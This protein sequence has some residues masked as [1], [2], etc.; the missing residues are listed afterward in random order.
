MSEKYTYS[1]QN[2]FP[3]S[4][5]NPGRLTEEIQDSSISGALD[6]VNTDADDDDCDIWF[7]ATSSYPDEA[8]LSGIVSTHIG[9]PLPPTPIS[10]KTGN[11]DTDRVPVSD[12]LGSTDWIHAAQASKRTYDYRI[13]SNI[14][15]E[16]VEHN[17][18]VW[19]TIG[20]VLFLG[21]SETP[22][23]EMKII[24]WVTTPGTVGSFR[25]YNYSE[26][27][28]IAIINNIS[29]EVKNIYNTTLSGMPTGEAILELQIRV[30]SGSGK[31]RLSSTLIG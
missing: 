24:S 30:D 25:L 5:V 11:L 4:A 12:G 14:S 16:Y 17:T 28:E 13:N 3:N 21:N 8:T 31:I 19:K 7:E 10:L 6:Y 27:S 18:D 26:S 9:T 2:D 23:S 29:S 1:I 20:N 15:D 22:V